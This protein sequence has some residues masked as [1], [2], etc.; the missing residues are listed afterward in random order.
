MASQ[1]T[2]VLLD[3]FSSGG[4]TEMEGSKGTAVR[5]SKKWIFFFLR[6]KKLLVLLNH[7]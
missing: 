1:K 6:K 5:G 2:R 3:G 4:G 7:R